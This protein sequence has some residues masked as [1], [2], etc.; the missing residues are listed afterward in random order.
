[1]KVFLQLKGP[2]K[3]YGNDSDTLELE[4]DRTILTVREIAEQL[5]IPTS[6]VSFIQV[7][8]SKSSLDESLK[9]GELIVFNPRV[10]GG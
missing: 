8:G 7:N 9:G 3:K 2:L 1:M 4:F 5:G 6:S 10:A